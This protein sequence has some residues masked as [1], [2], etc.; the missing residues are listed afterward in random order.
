[1]VAIIGFMLTSICQPWLAW[2]DLDE[3]LERHKNRRSCC[4]FQ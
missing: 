2:E 1:M 4:R 3:L